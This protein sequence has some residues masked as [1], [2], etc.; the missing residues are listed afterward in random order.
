MRLP[1][2]TLVAL[3]AL[4]DDFPLFYSTTGAAK[5]FHGF[6]QVVEVRGLADKTRHQGNGFAR[7]LFFIE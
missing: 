7:S 6:S 1:A 5:L 3:V 2:S 4:Y